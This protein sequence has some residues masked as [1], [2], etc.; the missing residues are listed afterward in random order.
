[1]VF[2][3]RQVWTDKEVAK[4]LAVINTELRSGEE[5]LE[6]LPAGLL[7][8]A[9][10]LSLL[11]ANRPLRRLLLLAERPLSELRFQDLFPEEEIRRAVLETFESAGKQASLQTRQRHLLRVTARS[12]G[13]WPEDRKAVVLVQETAPLPAPES[14]PQPLPSRAAPPLPQNR[15]RRPPRSDS[16][17]NHPRVRGHRRCAPPLV[18]RPLPRPRGCPFALQ[19]RALPATGGTSTST[20]PTAAYCNRLSKKYLAAAD[21]NL[22]TV[23]KVFDGDDSC[24]SRAMAG[25]R[26]GAPAG[27]GR[28]RAALLPGHSG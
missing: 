23:S 6:N 4:L 11:A 12:Y 17:R 20:G 10:D 3:D 19:D 9:P 5:V 27:L 26:D 25:P 13:S 28:G 7:V 1:M 15:R 21:K 2:A 22:N 8:V 14:D 18:R 16:G 24:R